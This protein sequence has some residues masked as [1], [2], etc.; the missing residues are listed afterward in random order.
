MATWRE[1]SEDS[2]QAAETLLQD[3]RYQSCISRAYYAAY[4]AATHEIIQKLTTFSHGRNNPTHELL[5]NYIQNNLTIPRARKNAADTY[6]AS[7]LLPRRC[8]LPAA[9]HNR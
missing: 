9:N 1:L 6:P 2:L 7:A 3:G 4:C 5:P 8:R